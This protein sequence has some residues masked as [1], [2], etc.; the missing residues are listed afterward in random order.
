MSA[1]LQETGS[2]EL[3]PV[4]SSSPKAVVTDVLK[5]HGPLVRAKGILILRRLQDPASLGGNDVLKRLA[6]SI[7]LLPRRTLDVIAYLE[8]YELLE[9]DRRAA[10]IFDL[11]LTHA[12]KSYLE[13][14]KNERI[15][16]SR[17][18]FRVRRATDDEL[19]DF[20]VNEPVVEA[21]VALTKSK[22]VARPPVRR[23]KKP[24]PSRLASVPTLP[25]TVRRRSG[26]S[27]PRVMRP[28]FAVQDGVLGR[29]GAVVQDVGTAILRRIQLAGTGRLQ[30][31]PT[32]LYRELTG[33]V[34]PLREILDK[35]ALE[36]HVRYESCGAN[37]FNVE[38]TEVGRAHLDRLDGVVAPKPAVV[39]DEAAVLAVAGQLGPKSA[40]Q[41]LAV[42]GKLRQDGGSYGAVSVAKSFGTVEGVSPAVLP[43]LV[44]RL[45]DMGLMDRRVNVR[46]PISTT[47]TDLGC[48]YLEQGPKVTEVARHNE[49]KRRSIA[50]PARTT[51]SRRQVAKGAAEPKPP[52]PQLRER[53]QLT[54]SEQRIYDSFVDLSKSALS[55]TREFWA[56]KAQAILERPTE[57]IA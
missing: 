53:H 5:P 56:R 28:S 40:Q 4:A 9:S 8:Q 7:G 12:G 47:L 19:E 44:K 35:L 51:A 49:G 45:A 29:F 46:V 13:L 41:A 1:M 16:A 57:A 20:D 38:L 23:A 48:A 6:E 39:V 21:P 3:A 15:E 34:T 2:D 36:G 26:S 18:I 30:L 42:L 22:T 32:T 24:A 33:V 10:L 55:H 11:K 27:T 37:T 54:P 31:S 17:L 43:N 25:P 14:V 50:Q 52:K